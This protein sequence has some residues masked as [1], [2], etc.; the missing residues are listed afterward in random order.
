MSFHSSVEPTLSYAALPSQWRAN[1]PPEIQISPKAP[2][3]T[4]ACAWQ[5]EGQRRPCLSGVSFHSSVQ[6]T[7][8]YAALPSQWRANDPPEIQISPKA[9]LFA[10]ACAWQREGQ[11]RPCL[12]GVS[13]HSS[14][15][16][17]LSYATLPSQWRANDPPEIQIS[18]KAPLF[19]SACAWQREG[20]R[21][22]CLSGVSF[23]SSVEP[24]LSYAALPSRGRA[25]DPPEIQISPKAPLFTSACAWQR[26][27]QRRPCLS[28]VS[29]NGARLQLSKSPSDFSRNTSCN[30]IATLSQL[31]KTSSLLKRITLKP[32]DISFS[33]LISS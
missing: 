26:E 13:F 21:R 4:S 1:D 20:Q 33:V 16:P 9:P 18:P 8:S 11:R 10:S 17:T 24:T 22:P 29:L 7:L 15:Q 2:L 27:G 25:N 32:K 28:G 12:S 14:V 30:S 3:F 23:H 19:A 31:F 5:R 6:P